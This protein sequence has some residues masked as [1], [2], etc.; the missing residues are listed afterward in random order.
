MLELDLIFREFLD[1]HYES[2][3]EADQH[4]FVELLS[5]SDQDL[6]Q[7]LVSKSSPADRN[8]LKIIEKI[9]LR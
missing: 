5:H 7:W 4:L 6:Q 8:L 1:N 2:L 9:I 3:T